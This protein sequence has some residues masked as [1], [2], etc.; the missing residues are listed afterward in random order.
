MTNC[1]L[2]PLEA[3]ILERLHKEYSIY[4]FPEHSDVKVER[5]ENTGVGRIVDLNCEKLV[6]INDGP[7]GIGK[8]SRIAMK[9]LEHFL[10][11]T[12]LIENKKLVQLEFVTEGNDH[13]DGVE[14]SW[15]IAEELEK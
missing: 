15:R 1:Q 8:F 4:G 3:A 2:T 10:L 9:G 14:R 13:W 12:V 11:V 7:I 5:R 6:E